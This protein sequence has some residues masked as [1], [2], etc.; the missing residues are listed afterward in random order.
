MEMKV[1]EVKQLNIKVVE[2]NGF[3]DDCFKCVFDMNEGCLLGH[4]EQ[5]FEVF[6]CCGCGLREDKKNVYFEIERTK[7]IER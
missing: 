6:G 5:L 3:E 7:E 4:N 1:G 2:S